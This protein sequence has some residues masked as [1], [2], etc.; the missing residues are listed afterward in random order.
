MTS[1]PIH[2]MTGR[3][4]R[5][6]AGVVLLGALVLGG[7]G[8]TGADTAM[9][10]DGQTITETDFLAGWDQVEKVGLSQAISQASQ[11]RPFTRETML[12]VLAYEP[13]YS[14]QAQQRKL[15]VLTDGSI[16]SI[17][18]RAGIEQPA[19]PAVQVAR[20]FLINQQLQLET[21][22]QTVNAAIQQ[23]MSDAKVVV[24][25]RFGTWDP[26]SVAVSGAT[27]NWL[28]TPTPS[29]RAQ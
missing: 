27:P 15:P 4:A 24:N 23:D 25:P 1:Q 21:D 17:F 28:P 2:R 18:H 8:T 10:V 22:A 14:R 3:L 29:A 6:T 11:G 19:G 26:R 20:W 7:C 13:A 5:T 16:S 9:V 12:T